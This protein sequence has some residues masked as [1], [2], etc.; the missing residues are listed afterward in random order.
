MKLCKVRLNEFG[1]IR[2]FVNAASSFDG[3]VDIV[4]G[5]HKINCKSL[6]GMLTLDLSSP[7]E[8]RVHGAHPEKFVDAIH[9]YLVA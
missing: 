7:V 4:T 6:L 9:A 1:E 8:L 5:S 2:D 3:A